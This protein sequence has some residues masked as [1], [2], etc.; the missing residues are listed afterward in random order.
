MVKHAPTAE[1]L[2]Q[3][4]WRRV[5]ELPDGELP[6]TAFNWFFAF[7]IVF[8]VVFAV[9]AT[10]GSANPAVI[11]RLRRIDLS[12]SLLFL[13]EYL[14]RLWVSPLSGRY[15]SG[16]RA[17][18][19]YLRSPFALVDL[20]AL[21]PLFVDML[22][23]ELYLVR[24]VRLLRVLRLSR[25]RR[26]REAVFRFN[27]ALQAKRSEL[28]VALVF[29]ATVILVSA[30]GLYL[31][32]GSV[33]PEHFG[34]IPR[35]LWWAVCTVTTVGYGDVVPVTVVGRLL[36]GLTALAGIGSIA[37]PTGILVV[38]FGEAAEALEARKLDQPTRRQGRSSGR[39]HHRQP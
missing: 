11:S 1:R 8:S 34:S 22:G 36:G 31:S 27:Y 2:R 14:L 13:A 30:T 33:Q 28:E 10:E 6:R 20:V 26:F 29:T 17:Y 38:G 18:L 39:R 19:R 15:G 23:S 35:A 5:G 37:I 24:L 4:I 32:E 16:W 3:G 9:L 25:S 12:I 21:L 7:L